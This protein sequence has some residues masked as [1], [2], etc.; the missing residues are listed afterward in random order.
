MEELRVDRKAGLEH[1]KIWTYFVRVIFV[2]HHA[3]T[4]ICCKSVMNLLKLEYD[5]DRSYYL[6]QQCLR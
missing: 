3:L 4:K 2:T 5:V 1:N 6:V